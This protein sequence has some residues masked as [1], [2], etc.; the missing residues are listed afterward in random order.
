MTEDEHAI[1]YEVVPKGT[2]VEAADGTQVGTVHKVLDNVREHIFDG[3]VV[4]TDDGRRF[5]D[6]PEVG[7]IT[8]RRVILTISPAE[9]GEL[10]QHKG[11]LGS[12]EKRAQRRVNRVKRRFER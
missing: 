6:A 3:I 11:L 9:V 1:G 7:R 10:P 2:P 4:A 8:N 12:L 5:V